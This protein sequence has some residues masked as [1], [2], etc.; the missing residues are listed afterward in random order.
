MV[1]SIWRAGNLLGTTRTF[2]PGVFGASCP[3]RQ[4]YTS[5]GV[6]SSLPG[7]KGQ[8][9]IARPGEAGAKLV[10]RRLRSVEMMTQRPTTGSFRSSGM[11]LLALYKVG[12]PAERPRTQC[13]RGAV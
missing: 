1:P 13:T 11:R 4:A 8:N 6:L 2:Q 12:V 9:V 3:G 7:Q 10:G 5:G